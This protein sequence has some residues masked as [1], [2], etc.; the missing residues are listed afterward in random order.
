MAENLIKDQQMAE[1]RNEIIRLDKRLKE[2][3]ISIGEDGPT[4]ASSP[5]INPM[6]ENLESELKIQKLT[7]GDLLDEAHEYVKENM[8]LKDEVNELASKVALV[9]SGANLDTFKSELVAE[10]KSELVAER[11]SHVRALSEKDTKIWSL[12]K[13]QDDKRMLLNGKDGEMTSLK[14]RMQIMEYES[15]PSL[16]NL[17]F[18]TGMTE[19]DCQKMMGDLRLELENEK[20]EHAVTQAYYRQV[21]DA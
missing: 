13:D 5:Q 7:N 20:S 14:A 12:Q 16:A 3:M 2:S 11:K 8:Q 15:E 4:F 17:P 1:L 18:S 10:F 19:A 6:I 9:S 21:D